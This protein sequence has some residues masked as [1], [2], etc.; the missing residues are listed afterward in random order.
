MTTMINPN[1]SLFEDGRYLER[2][3]GVKEEDGMMLMEVSRME[4]LRRAVA[5]VVDGR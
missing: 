1:S 3:A 4:T 2:E 5:E